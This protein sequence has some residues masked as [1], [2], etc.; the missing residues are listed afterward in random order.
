MAEQFRAPPGRLVPVPAGLDLR[1]ASLVEPLKYSCI[2]HEKA[3]R[4]AKPG[5]RGNVAGMEGFMEK[6]KHI[7]P[8]LPTPD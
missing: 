6:P 1:D 3:D 2:Y 8:D 5:I 4:M 7:V